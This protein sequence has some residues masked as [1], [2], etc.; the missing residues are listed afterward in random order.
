MQ[1]ALERALL[2]AAKARSADYG[3]FFQIPLLGDGNSPSTAVKE[4][5]ELFNVISATPALE[6]F[7][8]ARQC[9]LGNI[10]VINFRFLALWLI[11]RAQLVGAKQA[12]NDLIRYLEA[13]TIEITEILAVDGFSVEKKIELGEYE[14]IAWEDVAMTD[15]K[16][17]VMARSLFGRNVPTS[18]IVRQH[19]VQRRHDR[20]WD[21]SAPNV[22][23]SIEPALDILRCV[24]ALAGAGFRLLHYWFEPEEWA[25]WAVSSSNFGVDSTASPWRIDLTEALAPHI[26][27]SVASFRNLDENTQL[28]LRVPLDRLNRSYLAGMRSVDK[29]IELGIALE[30]LYAPTKLSEGIAYA[31]RTRAARFL[32]GT[33]E[34]RR[35]TVKLLTDVYDLRSRAVHTGRFDAESKKWLDE[36]RVRAVLES[37]QSLVGRSLVKAIQEG[38]PNW[39]EF[40]IENI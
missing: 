23:P 31:V 3:L 15:T 38:E 1:L 6:F 13:E 16:W 30:S 40:D 12:V 14:L 35:S 2:V 25:P 24:T 8:H 29:A 20:P 7:S 39:E 19:K 4:L 27:K 5:R 34:E 21:S 9:A 33:F 10:E 17:Q 28:R 36:T 18:V 37:G 26:N 11:S 32:G 22:R